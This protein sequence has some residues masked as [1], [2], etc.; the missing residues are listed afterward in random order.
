MSPQLAKRTP[1]LSKG[2]YTVKVTKRLSVLMAMARG[3][4]LPTRPIKVL[5]VWRTTP[6]N[7]N[8]YS[9]VYHTKAQAKHFTPKG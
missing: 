7:Q 3:I 5:K 9:Y 6:D 4:K 1:R 2:A 8:T